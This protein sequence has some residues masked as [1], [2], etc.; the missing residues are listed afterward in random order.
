MRRKL[1]DSEEKLAKDSR[2]EVRGSLKGMRSGTLM[3]GHWPLEQVS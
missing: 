3:F 1:R 2:S